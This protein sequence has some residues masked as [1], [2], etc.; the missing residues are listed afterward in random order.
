MWKAWNR[1]IS[2]MRNQD[3]T[4]GLDEH[5]PEERARREDEPDARVSPHRMSGSSSQVVI[6]PPAKKPR[7]AT[8]EGSCR[9]ARP[10]I[11]CPDVHPPA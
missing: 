10:V 8:S 11:A 5:E 4:S 1:N 6:R 7:T 2:W 9:S 3:T